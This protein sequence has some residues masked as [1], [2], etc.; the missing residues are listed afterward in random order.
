MKRRLY[1][2]SY[3]INELTKLDS[4]KLFTAKESEELIEI[5][6]G[7]SVFR[8]KESVLEYYL[9]KC[10]SKFEALEFLKNRIEEEKYQNIISFGSGS[11]VLEYLLYLSL[12]KDKNIVSSE[13]NNF[14]VEKSNEF[15]PEFLTIQFDFTKDTLSKVDT[16]FD[17]AVFFCSSYVM[18][19]DEFI[20]FFKHLKSEG[21]KEIIDFDSAFMTKTTQF[22]NAIRPIIEVAKKFKSTTSDNFEG[23]FHGYSRSRKE[24]LN[25]YKESGWLVKK[26]LTLGV[27]KFCA[28]LN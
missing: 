11:S 1:T 21:V 14:Y 17:I 28:V 6:L 27:Y 22:K 18:D 24:L 19:D 2:K 20:N 15:F 7:R 3:D 26:E 10:F 8:S 16:N 12:S 25:L 5:E 13:F 9:P 23:K 4:E